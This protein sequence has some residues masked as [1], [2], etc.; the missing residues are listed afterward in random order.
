MDYMASNSVVMG[1]HEL[2]KTWPEKDAI[3]FR[4]KTPRGSFLEGSTELPKELADEIV[5]KMMTHM[6]G[7]DW[8]KWKPTEK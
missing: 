8:R 6:N 5:G 7:E 3:A 1:K 4:Y 2:S